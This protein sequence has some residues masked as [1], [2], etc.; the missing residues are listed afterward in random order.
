M[1]LALELDAVVYNEAE[2]CK[3]VKLSRRTLLRARKSGEL[4]FLRFGRVVR[5]TER[6]IR[7]YQ[8]KRTRGGDA[9]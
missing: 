4:A 1:S 5:Y 2:A 9:S 7:D 3:R 8:Q 6:Q